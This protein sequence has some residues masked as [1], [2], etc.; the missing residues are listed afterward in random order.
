MMSLST[1]VR[2]AVRAFPLVFIAAA[3]A[4]AQASQNV[5]RR[6]SP[7]GSIVG[8]AYDSIGHALLTGA[9]IQL[10]P[11]A[12][13]TTLRGTA[14]TDS[15]GR[16][17]ISGVQAGR[18]AITFWHPVLDSLGLDAPVREVD[19]ADGRATSIEI[20]VPS[21]VRVRNAACG[22]PTAGDS[23]NAVLGMLRD[24][25][26]LGPLHDGSVTAQWVEL[27]A[28]SH[29]LV[30]HVSHISA[31]IAATG[32]FVLCGV[33]AQA[34]IS[35]LG[36]NGPD[37]TALVEMDMPVAG[38]VHRDLFIN[39]LPAVVAQAIA[40]AK[41]NPAGTKTLR[42]GTVVVHGVVV[43]SDSQPVAGAQVKFADGPEATTNSRGE[44]TI[45][46]APA[47]TQMV[48]IRAVGFYPTRQIVDVVDGAARVR[49]SLFSAAT[50]LDTVKVMAGH[51]SR[52]DP[53]GFYMRRHNPL[54]RFFDSAQVAARSPGVVSDL[55]QTVPELK[56]SITQPAGTGLGG[57]I[58]RAGE[59]SKTLSM[60]AIFGGRCSPVLYLNG[61][62]LSNIAFGA[63]PNADDIDRWI[64]PSEI[65][66]IEIYE[67]E[68]ETPLQ[69]RIAGSGCGAI[70]MWTH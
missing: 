3:V 64:T 66:G 17:T 31:H 40:E 46:G 24:A 47:G 27:R 22:Q 5:P 29:H 2:R 33:P 9:T 18:Y 44:W 4:G 43:R 62:R 1:L 28:E 6:Q 61:M 32:R 51:F 52:L 39:R 30:R 11:I 48:D 54:G 36:T 7:G 35:L 10:A 13:P 23:T 14:T 57:S 12:D 63:G 50:I 38:V 59:V 15:L 26:T 45:D 42:S 41:K 25:Q 8:V 20:G 67:S 68:F 70:L 56:I 58:N 37:S 55:F 16:F 49:T 34:T 60:R 19:V 21:P 53:N 65:M 69:Y